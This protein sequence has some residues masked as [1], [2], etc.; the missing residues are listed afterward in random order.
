L[1]TDLGFSTRVTAFEINS[2]F[3]SPV[4]SSDSPIEGGYGVFSSPNSPLEGGQGG[5][6]VSSLFIT[7]NTPLTPL[8][9]GIE[10]LFQQGN[11]KSVGL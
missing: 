6:S 7:T 8:K 1:S 5:V 4:D 9:G 11:W 10:N 3:N 2:L